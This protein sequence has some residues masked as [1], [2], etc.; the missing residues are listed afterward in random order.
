MKKTLWIFFCLAIALLVLI[1]G[2]LAQGK[3]GIV[4]AW[5]GHT[6]IGDGI[7]A[8][9]ILTVEKGNEGLAAKI[10]SETGQV[11]EM[12][13]RNVAFAENKLTFDVDFPDGM[14]FVLISVS[15]GL[16]GDTLKGSWANPDGSSDVIELVRK[17]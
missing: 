7:R 4:G 13:C 8:E 15:L 6:F 17:K 2:A 16:D 9:F 3:A 11:P 1:G 5:T 10:A 14:D 12:T